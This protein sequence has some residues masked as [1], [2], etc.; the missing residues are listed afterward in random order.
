MRSGPA[1]ARRKN[2]SFV[3][4]PPTA[5]GV[6]LTPRG[7]LE[8]DAPASHDGHALR[9]VERGAHAARSGDG[10]KMPDWWASSGIEPATD[11]GLPDTF[12]KPKGAILTI[13]RY[14]S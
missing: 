6:K 2:L 8:H 1:E 9:E 3:L 10:L 11:T 5:R 7:A 4:I 14:L 13:S 12:D